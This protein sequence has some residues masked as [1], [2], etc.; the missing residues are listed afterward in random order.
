MSDIS[1]SR[2]EVTNFYN[3]FKELNENWG[4]AAN[5]FIKA[6][7]EF[8][9]TWESDAKQEFVAVINDEMSPNF[10]EL[11]DQLNEYSNFLSDSVKTYSQNEEEVNKIISSL[12]L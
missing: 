3:Q 6:A 5:E 2:E 7:N 1:I 9:S 10:N 4:S 12:K 8:A 11:Q